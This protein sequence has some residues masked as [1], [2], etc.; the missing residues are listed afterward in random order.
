MDD[1]DTTAPQPA[2]RTAHGGTHAIEAAAAFDVRTCFTL[3]GAHVFPVYDA[4][5]GGKDAV[6]AAGD[7]RAAE[8]QGVVRLVDV[9]HEQTAVFA[10]EAMGKLTRR[11]GLAV[12]TAGP[13]VTNGVTAITG[14]F[15]NGSPLVVIGGRSPDAR[16]GSGAL[17][18]LDH[19]PILAPVTKQASTI[20]D[21]AEIGLRTRDAFALASQPH[22]G[23]VFLDVP[24]DVL[25]S[26][27]DLPAEGLAAIEPTHAEIDTEAIDRAAAAITAARHP[28]L[29][30]GSDTWMD[31][32]VESARRL[33]EESGI[34]VIANGMG[35]GVLPP[36]HPLLVTRARAAAF[37]GADLVIVV[38]TPLDFRLGYGVFGDPA[39]TVIHVVDSPSAVTSAPTCA[40]AL[41]GSIAAILDGLTERVLASRRTPDA[42]W[43]ASLQDAT[44]AS[45][46]KDAALLRSDARPI[47]PARII[48][49]LMARLTPDSIVI[50][51]GGDF[52]SFAGKYIEPQ[53][54]GR[55][56]DPGPY[57]ALGTGPGYAMAARIAHPDAPVFLLM[58]D[59]AAGFSFMD[60]E[61][62]MRHGLPVVIIIGNNAGWALER[63]PMRFLYGYD[64]IADLPA[65]RFD[66]IAASLG[67]AGE[68][69]EDPAAIGPA[70]DRAMASGVPSVVNVM[71]DPQAAYPRSTTGI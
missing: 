48:G 68:L 71:T 9:R 67:C 27:A 10:A 47:H 29:V 44:S 13:G 7:P 6:L 24:M 66:L 38:G 34:P 20:H 51:D 17:Q 16:W 41:A 32:A 26:W 50:G 1:Q 69:V 43:A 5:V 14:A 15:F 65:T 18:E 55:W 19:P 45:R 30:L 53:Q 59:G 46:A 40:I 39:A 61:T 37:A 12:L 49:E 23:P 58:G 54:P 63:H 70:I 4:A 11:P 21:T 56:L 3:S 42:Q 57:G 35:R 22:R 64:V 33:A 36:D 25:F 62:L 52:V 2:P 60:V 28:V 31:A 8:R